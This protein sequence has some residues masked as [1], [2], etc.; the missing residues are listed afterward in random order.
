MPNNIH[1]G[2]E[3]NKLLSRIP[4]KSQAFVAE[5]KHPNCLADFHKYLSIL[6][7]MAAGSIKAI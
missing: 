2:L 6:N 1:Q 7:Q 4:I 3:N 5:R